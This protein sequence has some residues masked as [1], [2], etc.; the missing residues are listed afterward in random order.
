[1]FSYLVVDIKMAVDSNSIHTMHI[2]VFDRIHKVKSHTHN[3]IFLQIN[4]KCIIVEK[5][6]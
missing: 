1:M 6:K 4:R 3:S 2:N 5:K